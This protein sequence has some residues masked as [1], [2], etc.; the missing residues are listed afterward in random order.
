MRRAPPGAS[1]PFFFFTDHELT[2]MMSKRLT[3]ARPTA[4]PKRP[5]PSSFVGRAKASNLANMAP[6]EGRSAIPLA[7][8]QPWRHH[9]RRG[10][11]MFGASGGSGE[12]N[13]GQSGA[14]AWIIAAARTP[15][16]MYI[17]PTPG[18]AG[19]GVHPC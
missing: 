6:E 17:Y 18:M 4:R 5:Q 9:K 11:T 1:E 12:K 8:A 14:Y 10:Y 3:P 16:D 15:L 13:D 2:A 7:T 19:V